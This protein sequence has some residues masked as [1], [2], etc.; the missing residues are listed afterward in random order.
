VH[1]RARS[2]LDILPDDGR[3]EAKN[4]PMLLSHRH[5]GVNLSTMTFVLGKGRMGSTANKDFQ[6]VARNHAVSTVHAEQVSRSKTD[7]AGSGRDVT[8]VQHTWPRARFE[9]VD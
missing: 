6:V 7:R 8:L 4:A 9:T 2:K 1:G 5:R 3:Q